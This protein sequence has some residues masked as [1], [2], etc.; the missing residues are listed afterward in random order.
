L[1][2]LTFAIWYLFF[3]FSF[4]LPF[5]SFSGGG[6]FLSCHTQR[7]W[8]LSCHT[9]CCWAL[10]CHTQCCWALLPLTSAISYIYIY[11]MYTYKYIYIYILY[12]YIYI[13]YISVYIY[14]YIYIHT[15]IYYIKNKNFRVIHSLIQR[16]HH[17]HIYII[18]G[19][20]DGKGEGAQW[21]CV[22]H[23]SFKFMWY[24]I[25]THTVSLSAL[26]FAIWYIYTHSLVEPLTFALNLCHLVYI[27][28]VV[29]MTI[30]LL[31]NRKILPWN[32]NYVFPM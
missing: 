32:H 8:A 17:C 27:S 22:P 11:N 26:T 30:Y 19:T 15:Y 21:D 18:A 7:C 16:P 6:W 25:Y 14:I 24:D 9:Q 28:R 13:C 31:S 10:S 4:C 12:I 5:L 2:A 1:S 3:F 20:A 23:E 29:I